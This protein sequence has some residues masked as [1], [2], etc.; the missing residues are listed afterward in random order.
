ME[1]AS[2]LTQHQGLSLTD[3]RRNRRPSALSRSFHYADKQYKSLLSRITGTT[4][5]V[6]DHGLR[7]RT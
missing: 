5:C 1:I 2:L 7:V 6:H 3:V 4:L